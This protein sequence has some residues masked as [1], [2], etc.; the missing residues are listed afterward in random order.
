MEVKYS[1]IPTEGFTKE[2]KRLSKKHPG[3]LSDIANLSRELKKDPK[4]G[5]DLG[6]RAFTKSGWLFQEQTK[7]NPVVQE[8]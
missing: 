5:T 3:I 6:Q 7:G 1:V 2:L 8:S 4:M